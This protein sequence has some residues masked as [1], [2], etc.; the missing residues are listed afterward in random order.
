MNQQ[1]F[2]FFFDHKLTGVI[3]AIDGIFAR[4]K[5]SAK[6]RLD[7]SRRFTLD[8][9]CGRSVQFVGIFLVG[10]PQLL[11]SIVVRAIYGQG[12]DLAVKGDAAPIRTIPPSR[13]SNHHRPR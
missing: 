4:S 9:V 8:R 1:R 11:K 5:S 2:I 10:N 3:R 12:D 13:R 7:Q 6:S